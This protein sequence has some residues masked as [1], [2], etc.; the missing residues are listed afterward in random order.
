M[1][2]RALRIRSIEPQ[3]LGRR[4]LA[5]HRGQDAVGTGLERQMQVRHQAAVGPM[6]LDQI[7]A[8]IAGMAGRVAQ[9]LQSVDLTQPVDQARQRPVFTVGAL[10]VIGVNVL[11]Q[12]RNL[13]NTARDQRLGLF[14]NE[15]SRPDV[16]TPLPRVYGTTQNVQNLSQPSW[17]VKNAVVMRG[18]LRCGQ[19]G[20]LVL[21]RESPP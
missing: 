15:L 14:G 6:R 12:Q 16:R 21:L 11:A 19:L 5:V 17:T 13:A 8:H 3:V 4:V 20:E 9:A 18:P 7:V 10:A 2:G 1:S